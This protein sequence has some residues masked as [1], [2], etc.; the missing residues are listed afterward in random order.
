ML[1]VI[2]GPFGIKIPALSRNLGALCSALLP[3]ARYSLCRPMVPGTTITIALCQ[4]LYFTCET[5]SLLMFSSMSVPIYV[6]IG[7][8]WLSTLIHDSSMK[9]CKYD[10]DGDK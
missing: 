4:N 8:V 2:Y 1:A 3:D 7:L 9:D 6:Q 5:P 10:S